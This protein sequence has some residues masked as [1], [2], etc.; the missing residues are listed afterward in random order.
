MNSDVFNLELSLPEQDEKN[1]R[2]VL[3]ERRLISERRAASNHR[4]LR[5]LSANQVIKRQLDNIGLLVW[6]NWISRSCFA[7]C[8][9][10]CI[11]TLSWSYS[12][13]LGLLDQAG[14][15]IS[16]KQTL[17]SNLLELQN[18][19]ASGKYQSLHAQ[20]GDLYQR[21]LPDY[22]ALAIWLGKLTD[23]ANDSGL[24]LDYLIGE[25]QPVATVEHVMM[26][27]VSISLKQLPHVA[28]K[29]YQSSLTFLHLLL[30]E[31]WHLDI[32]SL[33]MD[34]QGEGVETVEVRLSLWIRS[35]K[36]VLATENK[37][38]EIDNEQENTNIFK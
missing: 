36:T 8:V 4:G 31:K 2:R 17:A 37:A 38:E 15:S 3:S 21:V 9:G 26:V 34:S 20:V 18:T 11:S 32:T 30:R 23:K 24:Q 6:K 14:S 1:D 19:W 10:I 25:G 28:D 13:R 33:R 16:Q 35:Q 12:S 29:V 5:P 7:I 22:Q 27:P